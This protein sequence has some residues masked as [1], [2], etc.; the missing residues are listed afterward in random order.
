MN[1]YK[2]FLKKEHKFLNSVKSLIFFQYFYCVLNCTES[3]QNFLKV[4]IWESVFLGQI[5]QHFNWFSKAHNRNSLHLKI[6]QFQ[7]YLKQ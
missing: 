7:F 3:T 6:M 1:Y 4:Q 2:Q 5:F